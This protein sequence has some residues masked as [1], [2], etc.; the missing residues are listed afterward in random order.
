[1]AST[2]YDAVVVGSG[3]SG[4]W[5]AKELTQGV[6]GVKAQSE[7]AAKAAAEQARTMKEIAKS[8]DQSSRDIRT[9]AT[10]NQQHSK[11]MSKRVGQLSE[12]RRITQRNAE[13]VGRTRTG[14]AELIDQARALAMQV[15]APNGKSPNGRNGR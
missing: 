3:A 11:G 4:G 1:M 10:G 13:G 15:N 14:T 5:A 7:Q 9:V 8:A 2:I 6:T 12:I